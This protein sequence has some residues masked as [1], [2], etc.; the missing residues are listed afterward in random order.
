MSAHHETFT[1]TRRELLT[2]AG[3]AVL[4]ACGGGNGGNRP[5]SPSPT[6][7]PAPPAS[8]DA[9]VAI[10]RAY[11][12]GDS[13][14]AIEEGL[15]LIGGIRD[16]VGGKVVTV[17][18][19]L[20]GY[21]TNVRGL[22]AGETYATHGETVRALVAVLAAN[23]ARLVRIV[24][25]APQPIPLEAYA[26]QFGWDTDAIKAKYPVEF[27]NTRNL[28]LGREYKRLSV[29]GGMMFEYFM[30]NHSYVDT[31]VYVSLS[32]M[33]NHMIAGVTLGLKNSFG[34]TPNSLYG[35]DAP[36]EH[37][38]GNRAGI[39][40]RK[41]GPRTLPGATG[42]LES[43][44]RYQRVPN[45]VA[46]ENAARPIHL[47]VI[48]AVSTMSG[49]EG[50]WSDLSDSNT[51][52]HAVG[53]K[54]LKPGCFIIGRDPVATDAVAIKA[55]GYDDP[56]SESLPPFHFNRTNYLKI[57]SQTYRLGTADLAK[58][59]VRGTPIAQVATRFAWI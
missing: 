22:P 18:V 13:Q 5:P 55:M 42:A 49:G 53:L 51:D 37:A 59:E 33:K 31:D 29:P 52:P 24:E 36:D 44:D 56:L 57:A 25:S 54:V 47:S 39:H 26:A 34:I 32:K 14:A 41:D 9:A 35:V 20:T 7:A 15:S 40:E 28:G 58:I 1:P 43:A 6:P 8:Y 50:P 23:G 48:E 46:E 11:T 4:G 12:F 21:S 17:K 19:N 30:V 2:A 3:M 16:L 10:T 45:V 38:E 27:E